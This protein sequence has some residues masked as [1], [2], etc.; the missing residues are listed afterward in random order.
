MT[1]VISTSTQTY[2]I[3]KDMDIDWGGIP[4][5]T[6]KTLTLRCITRPYEIHN[7]QTGT[8]F[9]FQ[10]PVVIEAYERDSAAVANRKE[11]QQLVK[12]EKQIME[13]ISLNKYGLQEDGISHMVVTGSQIRPV[14]EDEMGLANWFKLTM[15][16][17]MTY[18]LQY[19]VA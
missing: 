13:F 12:L 4:D 6:N 1:D 15:N 9:D 2:S 18:R 11:P 3:I 8:V 16:V 7:D 14:D 5:R 17:Q 19:T 10:I